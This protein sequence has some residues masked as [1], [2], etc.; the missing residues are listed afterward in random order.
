[1]EYLFNLDESI[2]LFLNGLN[3]PWLDPVMMLLTDGKSWAPLFLLL[4]GWMIYKFKW[5]SVAMLVFIGLTI[6]LAD[7]V[8]S[9]LLKPMIGRLRPSHNPELESVIHLVNGYKGGLYGFVSSHAANAFGVATLLW[10]L[11]RKHARWI[12]LM[13]LWAV[14]FSYT[15]IYLG[16]HYPADI[17]AGG[18]IGALIGYIFYQLAKLLPDKNSPIPPI[19]PP[20]S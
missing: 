6:T 7:Q 17:I 9:S 12:W 18:L 1:M 13:F 10:F 15:R 16:V 20:A 5:Q 2:F 3:T 4:I 19:G 11:F 14:L 8:S